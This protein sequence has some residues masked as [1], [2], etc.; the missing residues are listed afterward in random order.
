MTSE[1]CESADFRHSWARPEDIETGATDGGNVHLCVCFDNYR[2]PLGS[3]DNVCDD[4]GGVVVPGDGVVREA[5][6]TAGE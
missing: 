4:A 5:G 3:L 2:W 1:H 6:A